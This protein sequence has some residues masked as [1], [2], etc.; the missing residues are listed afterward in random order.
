MKI[1]SYLLY[2]LT[3]YDVNVQETFVS[4]LALD[5]PRMLIFWLFQMLI[6]SVGSTLEKVFSPIHFCRTPAYW[7]RTAD[8]SDCTLRV[9]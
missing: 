6:Q 4:F 9:E 1:K 2:N 3:S 8:P 7:D 5:A